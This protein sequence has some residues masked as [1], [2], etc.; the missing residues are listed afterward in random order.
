MGKFGFRS[1]LSE[2]DPMRISEHMSKCLCNLLFCLK[3]QMSN[4]ESHVLGDLSFSFS[5]L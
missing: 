4:I 1:V 2:V 3:P 5:M